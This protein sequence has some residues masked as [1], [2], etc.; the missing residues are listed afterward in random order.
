M[1][2]YD[3]HAVSCKSGFF[4]AQ[5]S[6]W[7][8]LQSAL[9]CPL[10]L[11]PHGHFISAKTHN[12][13]V[14]ELDWICYTSV[15]VNMECHAV[16]AEPS[17]IQ[18][19]AVPD[20]GRIVIAYKWSLWNDL[21]N[22]LSDFESIAHY[23]RC[24]VATTPIGPAMPV[25]GGRPSQ[26]SFAWGDRYLYIQKASVSH[27]VS[28]FDIHKLGVKLA[29]FNAPSQA[30]RLW[31]LKSW[32]IDNTRLYVSFLHPS[33]VYGVHLVLSQVHALAVSFC[34]ETAARLKLCSVTPE[35][36][37]WAARNRQGVVR[38]THQRV[39]HVPQLQTPAER[40]WMPGSGCSAWSVPSCQRHAR[41]SQ[42]RSSNSPSPWRGVAEGVTYFAT[43]SLKLCI[44]S[45][46]KEKHPWCVTQTETYI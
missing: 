43:K 42:I 45:I 25:C 15:S 8:L 3:F 28:M 17:N 39:G 11:C 9:D 13:K 20:L 32:I 37:L 4:F 6:C 2:E 38:E 30:S 36:S 26:T 41:F 40:C 10:S 23:D 12:R 46:F 14:L 7:L 31:S 19:M 44:W 1:C 16:C 33:D 24:P 34:K 5:C 22:D 29:H 18:K 27:A 21:S 35:Q